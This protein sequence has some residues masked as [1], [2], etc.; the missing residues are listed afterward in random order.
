MDGAC[1]GSCY[2]LNVQL[3]IDEVDFWV[4][5]QGLSDAELCLCV[6]GIVVLWVGGG[7]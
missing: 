3:P 7:I 6:E 5:I 2:V 4:D 1:G